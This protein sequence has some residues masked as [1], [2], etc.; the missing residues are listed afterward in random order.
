MGI[1]RLR[2]TTRNLVPNDTNNALDVFVCDRVKGQTRRV[3]VGPSDRR[4]N[5][6]SVSAVISADG[7][8]VAVGCTASNLVPGDT[9]GADDT[10]VRTLIP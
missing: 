8:S 1:F 10:F 4:G 5:E 6:D 3:S 9:D 7:R 2:H